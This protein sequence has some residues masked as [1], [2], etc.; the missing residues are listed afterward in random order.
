M[1]K[2]AVKL[3]KMA[4]MQF[5]HSKFA[6]SLEKR[7]GIYYNIG[8]CYPKMQFYDLKIAK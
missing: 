7:F 5:L 4:K 6:K 2:G 8:E 3:S 1:Q